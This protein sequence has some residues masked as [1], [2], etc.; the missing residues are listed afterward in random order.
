MNPLLISAD[1]SAQM[2]GIG[3]TLFYSMHSSG[4]LGPM[5]IKLG[6][7][8]L[9]NRK[10]MEEWVGLGCPARRQ[11]LNRKNENIVDGKSCLR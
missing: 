11:W 6:R 10:E 1:E 8:S 5:P 3:R 9:W 2:L 4:R 7:R